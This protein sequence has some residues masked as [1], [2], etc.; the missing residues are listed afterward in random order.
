MAV[1]TRWRIARMC[2]AIFG[3]CAMMVLS[4][5]PTSQPAARTRRAHPA[6]CL[7]QQRDRVGT[8]VL[9]IGVGEMK[10]DVTH[11]RSAE[12]R[13]GDRMAQRVGIRVTE[14]AVRV[15]DLDTAEH[16]LA[17]GDERMRVPAFADAP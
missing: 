15:R 13:I 12:Q 11:R 5:L 8:A 4:T 1:A 6:C 14:Q 9:L 7:G 17:A 10:T 2:G 3:D 16:E